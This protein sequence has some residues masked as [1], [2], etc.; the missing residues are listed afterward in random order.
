MNQSITPVRT[1][2][3]MVDLNGQRGLLGTWPV[4]NARCDRGAAEMR[5]TPAGR[6]AALPLLGG[7]SPSSGLE[8]QRLVSVIQ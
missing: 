2:L 8:G 6:P 4:T 3:Q 1:F 5:R 7:H